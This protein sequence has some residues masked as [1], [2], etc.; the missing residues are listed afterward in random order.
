MTGTTYQPAG[1]QG[2][3][4]DPC[5]GAGQQ[6]LLPYVAYGRQPLRRQQAGGPGVAV[7]LRHQR[8]RRP[9]PGGRD[10]AVGFLCY[11]GG[12]RSFCFEERCLEACKM[13]DATRHARG[14]GCTHAA[15][16]QGKRS[17]IVDALVVYRRVIGRSSRSPL[18]VGFAPLRNVWCGSLGDGLKPSNNGQLFLLDVFSSQVSSASLRSSASVLI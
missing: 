2:G 10:I 15:I 13:Q 9:L 11:S 5:A 6:Q 17:G 18:M 8:P 16:K 1:P 14:R 7:Y 12:F 4:A 3:G